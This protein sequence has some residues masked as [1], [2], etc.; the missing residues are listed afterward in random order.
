MTKIKDNME[1]EEIKY[2]GNVEIL[3]F[4]EILKE[5]GWDKI[6]ERIQKPLKNLKVAPY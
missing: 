6:K 1:N 3:H 2:S 5:L 4:L